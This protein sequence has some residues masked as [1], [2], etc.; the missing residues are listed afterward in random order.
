MRLSLDPTRCRVQMSHVRHLAVHVDLS[1]VLPPRRPFHA[2]LQHVPVAGWRRLRLWR[3][4]CY[5]GGRV[6]KYL[7]SIWLIYYCPRWSMNES[8]MTKKYHRVNVL[9]STYLQI[10]YHLMNINVKI[11]LCEKLHE[12]KGVWKIGW[13]EVFKVTC[14]MGEGQEEDS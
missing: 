7:D 13:Q 3:Q 5:E 11:G 14:N 8:E 2:R 10:K 1:R 12:I 9:L 4:V 6:R